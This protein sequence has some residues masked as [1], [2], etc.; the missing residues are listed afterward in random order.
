MKP[1]DEKYCAERKEEVDRRLEAGEQRFQRVE[2]KLDK[3]LWVLVS[4]MGAILLAIISS[5]LAAHSERL[6][7]QAIDRTPPTQTAGMHP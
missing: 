2:G 3:F 5:H 6:K 1:V 4:G 7:E